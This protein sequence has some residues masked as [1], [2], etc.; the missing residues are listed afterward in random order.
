MVCWCVAVFDERTGVIRLHWKAHDAP[1]LKLA[2]CGDSLLLTTAADRSVCVWDISG[3]AYHAQH[4]SA[5][6]HTY[7][8]SA[9]HSAAAVAALSSSPSSMAAAALHLARGGGGGGGGG[10]ADPSGAAA[11]GGGVLGGTGGLSG[12]AGGAGGG[13][14]GGSEGGVLVQRLTGATEPVRHALVHGSD[15]F[16]AVGP[17]IALAP[18]TR[19]CTTFSFAFTSLL[20]CGSDPLTVLCSPNPSLPLA[21]SHRL[22]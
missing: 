2:A 18:I 14:Y 17:K 9:S 20:L 5:A 16:C 1:I 11:G 19:V 10:G 7:S 15:V 8:Y 6:A 4:A 3:T 13:G 22:R 21:N 12:N